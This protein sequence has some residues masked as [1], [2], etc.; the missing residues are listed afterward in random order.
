MPIDLA[1][2]AI[3]DEDIATEFLKEDTPVAPEKR[4]I[5]RLLINGITREVERHCRRPFVSKAFTEY[6]DGHSGREL[7]LRQIPIVSVTTVDRVDEDDT[8]LNAYTSTDFL[9]MSERGV[10]RFKD[11]RVFT[12]GV[13]NWKVVYSAGYATVPEDVQTAALYMLAV[14]WRDVENKRQDVESISYEGETINYVTVP[15]PDKA[16]KR[17]SG[18]RR[19]LV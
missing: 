9:I 15:M 17:L 19:K 6:Y 10:L 7:A 13:W 14:A 5:L 12:A 8:S 4:E 11:G 16:K 3:L 18:W 1:A 2:N